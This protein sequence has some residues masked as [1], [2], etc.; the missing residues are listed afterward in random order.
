MKLRKRTVWASARYHCGNNEV[1]S[2]EIKLDPRS[3]DL[4]GLRPIDN[5][6][7]ALD[8]WGLPPYLHQQ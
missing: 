7:H 8:G 4:S 2:D 6:A 5:S 3:L 1:L